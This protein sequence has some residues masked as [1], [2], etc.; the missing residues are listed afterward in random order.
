MDLFT[1]PLSATRFNLLKSNL[2]VRNLPLQLQGHDK[3]KVKDTT[4]RD[5]VNEAMMEEDLILGVTVI[6]V[7]SNVNLNFKFLLHLS[8]FCY[9]QLLYKSP[10]IDMYKIIKRIPFTIYWNS[11]TLNKSTLKVTC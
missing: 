2:K 11:E 1:K 9:N 3:D 4:V 6:V 5:Q 8:V 7:Y 10:L